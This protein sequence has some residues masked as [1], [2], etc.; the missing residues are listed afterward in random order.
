MKMRLLCGSIHERRYIH[1]G[2]EERC[3][4]TGLRGEE[5]NENGFEIFSG[6]VTVRGKSYDVE[7]NRME[8]RTIGVNYGLRV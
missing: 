1:H 6:T 4:P 8:H 7:R 5:K 3:S 2:R